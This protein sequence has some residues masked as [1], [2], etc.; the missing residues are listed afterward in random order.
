MRE[1][2]GGKD[3]KGCARC[4]RVCEVLLR[5]TWYA[6]YG[7]HPAEVLLVPVEHEVVRH[8]VRVAVP[9]ELDGLEGAVTLQLRHDHVMLEVERGEAGVGLHA[10]HEVGRRLVERACRVSWVGEWMGEW[11]SEQVGECLGRHVGKWVSG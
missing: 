10:P 3:Y 8:A 2:E 5:Y 6:H 9:H 4:V 1:G 11:V 7:S